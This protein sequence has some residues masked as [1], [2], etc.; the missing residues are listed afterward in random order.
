MRLPRTL[1]VLAMTG[2][3]R[4]IVLCLFFGIYGITL[5]GTGI[6]VRMN[7]IAVTQ[8]MSLL[9]PS[10]GVSKYMTGG[11]LSPRIISSIAH[12]IH[13]SQNKK[14]SIS[15]ERTS[16]FDMFSCFPPNKAYAMCPPSSCPTGIR[17][18]AVTKKPIH[19]ANAMGCKSTS[20]DSGRSPR[21]NRRKQ[22]E[23]QGVSERQAAFQP[24]CH[25]YPGQRKAYD[26]CHKRD[27]KACYG[28]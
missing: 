12:I 13:P 8:L 28:A 20:Y 6:N 16:I 4:F 15:M 26:D 25:Y 21:I 9:L 5:N 2:N 22:R 10:R 7:I 17:F 27:Y 3:S 24:F 11:C 14:P 18:N 19:P 1:W 23:K